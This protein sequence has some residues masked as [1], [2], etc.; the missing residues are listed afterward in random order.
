MTRLKKKHNI[1]DGIIVILLTIP[2]FFGIYDMRPP[3]ICVLRFAEASSWWSGAP[4]SFQMGPWDAMETENSQ[5]IRGGKNVIIHGKHHLNH[6]E[7]M[8]KT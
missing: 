7:S 6:L 3:L 1:T 4:G 5:P 8:A 2:F